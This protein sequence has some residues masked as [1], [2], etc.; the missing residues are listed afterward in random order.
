M[1]QQNK[2]H[3]IYIDSDINNDIYSCSK[4]LSH[5]ITNVLRIGSSE[6]IIIFND[7]EEQ[8]LCSVIINNK[9]VNLNIIKRVLNKVSR[10]KQ[11]SLAVSIVSMRVMDLI[12]QKSVELGAINFSPVYTS[13]SQYK[14]VDKKIK[15]WEKIIIHSSEQ[16]GRSELMHLDMPLTLNEF[17]ENQNFPPGYLLHQNGKEFELDDFH[18]NNISLFIG[19]EGGFEENEMRMFDTNKWKIKKISENILRTETA[20]I[21]ALALVNNYESLSRHSI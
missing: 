11:I 9:N 15:H 7:K 12:I 14:D 3:R 18:Q 5:R 13:R 6:E 19:P 21:S 1:K 17:M 8:Y 20:C 4:E 2:I 16:S 10:K